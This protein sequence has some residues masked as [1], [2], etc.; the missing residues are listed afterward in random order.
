MIICG[1]IAFVVIDVLG[2]IAIISNERK[3]SNKI[4]SIK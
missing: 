4:I 1:L 3:K 2:V